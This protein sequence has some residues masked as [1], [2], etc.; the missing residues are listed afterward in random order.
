MPIGK[1][2]IIIWSWVYR[3][4]GLVIEAGSDKVTPFVYATEEFKGKSFLKINK[5]Q[6]QET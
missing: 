2:Q 3:L 6:S 1:E 5:Q 4:A